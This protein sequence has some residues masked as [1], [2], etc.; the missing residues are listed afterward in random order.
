MV[1]PKGDWGRAATTKKVLTAMPIA[2]WAVIFP[3]SMESDAKKFCRTLSEQGP[4]L[5]IQVARP[6]V[7]P[8][9]SD[10]TEAYLNAMR[11]LAGNIDLVVTIFSS[12]QRSDRYAAI[13]KFCYVE[14]PMASQV[15]LLR[16]ENV[17]QFVDM[18]KSF[19]RV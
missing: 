1:G 11:E 14:H 13:K 10:R 19:L 2:N 8:I 7:V 15:T 18:P 4:R 12:G 16:K 5:G 6:R 9:N 17:S 3:T